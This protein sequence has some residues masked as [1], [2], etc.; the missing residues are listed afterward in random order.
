[1]SW[2]RN[3][4]LPLVLL[5]GGTRARLRARSRLRRR[6]RGGRLSGTT[7]SGGAPGT[8]GRRVRV[9]R[10]RLIGDGARW[11]AGACA[12]PPRFVRYLR[13]ATYA[14]AIAIVAAVAI[15]AL[16]GA[17]QRPNERPGGSDRSS[18]A[19]KARLEGHRQGLPQI[20]VL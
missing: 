5:I 16:V 3:A 9:S 17:I 1:M 18:P 15:M 2:F 19:T 14:L 13:L 6:S 8:P 10:L 4:T 7:P 20:S 11:R 12:D